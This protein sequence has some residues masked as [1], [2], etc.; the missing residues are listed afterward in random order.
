MFNKTTL[1]AALI[2]LSLGVSAPL[3]AQATSRA[4]NEL[5]SQVTQKLAA[6]GYEV[7]KVVPE[8]GMIEVYAIKDG[9]MLEVYLD[10][11]LNIV[12]VKQR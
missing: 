4:S 9:Q 12:R 3:A 10:A 11:D 1:T 2:A 8:N 6:D 7:R 5:R